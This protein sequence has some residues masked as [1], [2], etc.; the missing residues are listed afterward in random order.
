M[1]HVKFNIDVSFFS[2]DNKVDIDICIRDELIAF[3]LAK[4][5]WFSPMFDL[6]VGEALG[7]FYSPQSGSWFQCRICWWR[8]WFK[9][10]GEMWIM[11]VMS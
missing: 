5:Q 2:L 4:M 3:V 11:F 8:A 1:G 9:E 6:L 7:L 10:S